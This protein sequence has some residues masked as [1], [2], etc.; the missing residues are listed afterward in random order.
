MDIIEKIKERAD[1]VEI[2]SNYT[3]LKKSGRR[4]V[5]LCPFH[6]EKT[7]SFT[8]DQEKGLYHCFGCGAG[9]DIFTLVMEKEGLDF[10]S[11]VE[12]LARKYNISIPRKSSPTKKIEE[13]IL[14]INSVAQ[15][16]F[17]SFLRS[18][19]GEQARKYIE[20]RSI[21]EDF[22]DFLGLGYSPN[23]G[24][25]LVKY[26]KNK[27][28]SENLIS[29][30]GLG[31]KTER[32][33]ID[34]F[35]GRIMFPIRNISGQIIAFGGRT[36]F[37]ENP[38]YM[39]SPETPV[40]KKRA[41]LF[42]LD[43]AKEAIKEKG[44]AILVEGYMDQISLFINGFKNCVAS[45][46]TSLTEEQVSLLKK[47]SDKIYLFYDKD[48]AGVSSTI[49][50][51]PV[52]LS[53]DLSLK[54]IVIPEG[55]D[56]DGYIREKGRDGLEKILDK[57]LSP[58]EFLIRNYKLNEE[59]TPEEKSKKIKSI[60]EVFNG[61]T[62]PILKR[63]YVK[64]LSSTTGFEEDLILRLMNKKEAL[65]PQLGGETATPAEKKLIYAIIKDWNSARDI[66]NAL[67][68]LDLSELGQKDIINQLIEIIEKKGEITPS[69]IHEK[70]S[71]EKQRIIYKILLEEGEVNLE[72]MEE[73]LKAVKKLILEKK[74]RKLQ[75][76]I[77]REERSGNRERL[78]ELLLLKQ[79]ITQDIINLK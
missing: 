17:Q 75:D 25:S 64:E 15:V 68:S 24:D 20:G 28:Y 36:I 5:G 8:V 12:F 53:H 27:G 35:R 69:L 62:D 55:K 78:K 33:L 58:V 18:R 72:E 38:K 41:Q 44:F 57:A 6:A 10:P 48:I 46:G 40:Y 34:R 31:V 23:S 29:L 54:I 73:C 7:P 65:K 45:L 9:G 21:K 63:T 74:H 22:I 32:G 61:I 56:P 14:E 3:R 66:V 13:E 42:G 26:L 49:R 11:A 37:D 19:D 71:K 16:F 60:I 1:I 52:I 76:E 70:F 39:N 77:S 30:S 59:I 50:A 79:K 51:I 67:R 2:V 4:Y 47:F 43:I